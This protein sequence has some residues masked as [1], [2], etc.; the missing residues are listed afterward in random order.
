MKEPFYSFS[1]Y[2]KKK[3][4]PGKIRKIAVDAGFPCPN[5]DGSISFKGCVFCDTYGSGPISNM[6][7]S[8]SIQQQIE[9]FVGTKRDRNYIAYYQPHSNTCAPLNILRERYEVIFQYPE[10]VG[11]F[12]GTR[13][14]AIADEAYPLL[15]DMSQR[16]FLT[17]ELGLQSIHSKSLKFLN[18]NHSYQQF[19]DTFHKLKNLGIDVL[20]HL[21]VG[22]PGESHDEIMASIKEM[23]RLKP[24]G[25]KFHAMHVLRNTRLFD[26]YEKKQFKLMEKEEYLE[27]II[28][29]LEHLDPDIVVHRLTGER[30]MEIFHAPQWTAAKAKLINTIRSKMQKEDTYQGR[31]L[32][33]DPS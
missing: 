20:V 12:I 19:L 23:N 25:V 5:K 16:T 3:F 22:I 28:R 15:E 2:L 10:I 4:G 31:L 30:D 33:K 17:V 1:A 32:M 26:M 24:A 18:R 14:D 7:D 13:P 8:L 6:K 21:I 11:L 9:N 29:L 27:L